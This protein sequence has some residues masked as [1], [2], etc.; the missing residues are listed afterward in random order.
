LGGMYS[1]SIKDNNLEYS[2]ASNYAVVNFMINIKQETEE[3]KKY[4]QATG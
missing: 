3:A 1:E 2:E 4:R